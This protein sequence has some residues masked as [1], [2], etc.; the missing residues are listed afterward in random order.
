MTIAD[1][2]SLRAE[3]SMERAITRRAP[4]LIF[5]S[6]VTLVALFVVFYPI[7]I[8]VLR[9]LFPDGQPDPLL[10]ARTLSSSG[11]LIAVRNTLIIAFAIRWSRFRWASSSLG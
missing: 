2:S 7:A 1:T 8:I 6:V 3:Q 4:V 5:I 10:W 9:A 11:L